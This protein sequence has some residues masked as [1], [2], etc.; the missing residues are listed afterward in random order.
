MAFFWV[1]QWVAL[2]VIYEGPPMGD[3]PPGSRP[4]ALDSAATG[5]AREGNQTLSSPGLSPYKSPDNST[6]F[7][8]QLSAIPQHQ[9]RSDFRS[10]THATPQHPPQDH[11]AS[12][13]NMASM[14][15]ALPEYGPVDNAIAMQ[16]GS[17]S[18][19]RSLSGASTSAVVY[20]LGQNLQMPTQAPGSMSGHQHYGNAYAAGP[21]QQQA[22]VQGAQ[23]TAYPP[24]AAGQSRISSNYSIPSPYMYYPPPYGHPSQY[25]SGYSTQGTPSQAMYDRRGSMAGASVGPSPPSMEFQHHDSVFTGARIG[26]PEQATMGP[27][28]GPP[29]ARMQGKRT[30]L[31]SA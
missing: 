24:F 1:Q 7:Y 8:S 18:I 2:P 4:Q 23:H 21:Y 25:N 10:P 16:H 26:G 29:F 15:G 14:A 3:L 6:P 20:Q 19:P 9:P 27:G 28:F 31:T 5:L 30:S 12:S 11:G 22:F 17:Q 13:M